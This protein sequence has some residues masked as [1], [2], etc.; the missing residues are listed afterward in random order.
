M[1]QRQLFTAHPDPE[2]DTR[3]EDLGEIDEFVTS[4][5]GISD[6]PYRD[7]PSVHTKF[8]ESSGE[9]DFNNTV[10][11]NERAVDDSKGDIAQDILQTSPAEYVSLVHSSDHCWDANGWVYFQEDGEVKNEAYFGEEDRQG[12]DVERDIRNEFGI[13]T[14]VPFF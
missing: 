8:T 1:S 2:T 10:T 4:E 13:S 5:Y 14:N 9:Q 3:T 11:Y 12:K 7:A 6:S